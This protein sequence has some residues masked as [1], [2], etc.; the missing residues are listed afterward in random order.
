MHPHLDY[1]N[2][3]YDVR[4]RLVL[5]YVWELPFGKHHGFAGAV[6]NGWQFNGIFS[7]QTGAHWS[8]YN[9]SHPNLLSTVRTVV[10][11]DGTISPASCDNS[12][13]SGNT[14]VNHGGDYLLNETGFTS[15]DRNSRPDS[16]IPQYNGATHA[17]WANGYGSS[18]VCHHGDC[19]TSTVFSPPSCLA[20]IGNMARNQFV[21]PGQWDA[22]MSLF[23]NFKIT[24][25]V[26]LQFR[27]EGFNVF[28]HTNFLLASTAAGAG[29][30]HNRVDQGLFGQAGATLNSRNLQFGAKITF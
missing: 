17:M 1:G 9:R 27:A 19:T 10:N 16:N 2:S 23:K 15:V 22:D 12:D 30:P 3:I 4:Q 7:A 11:P 18:W 28:N 13:V 6:V 20:C 25:R 5:S 29:G 24:E 8:P 14:C 26:G 21:G